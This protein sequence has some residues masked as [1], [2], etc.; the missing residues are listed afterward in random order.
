MEQRIGI[1]AGSGELPF[2][3][4]KETQK[5]GYSCMVVGIQ[6]QTDASLQDNVDEFQWFEVS[7]ILGL[8]SFFKRNNIKDVI[9]AGKIDHRIIFSQE[10]S[11]QPGLNLLDQLR[12][13]GP[14]AII[15]AVIEFMAF[16]GISILDPTPFIAS[17]FCL[18][19]ILTETKPSQREEEDIV[20]GWP[21]ARKLADSDIGQTL[22]VKDKAI[23]ALEGMEGT[24]ETIKRGGLLA[25][26][27]TVGIKMSRSH[28][29]TR[30]DLPAI[31]LNT[32]KSLVEAESGAFCFEAERVPFFQQEEAISMADENNIAMI[33]K[34][35]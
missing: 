21:I 15:N 19:G 5:L 35:S 31:G 7:A 18:E 8:I 34:K 6:G 2:L 12:D 22:I 26:K 23:V 28:Q 20:F 17:A 13:K 33:A 27:G 9:F 11:K 3:I 10:K 1:I 4:L 14:T 32:I 16:Q 25:G 29:D 24:D 30:I